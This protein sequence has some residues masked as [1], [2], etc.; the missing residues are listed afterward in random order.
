MTAEYL[1]NEINNL[2]C[3]K[4][5]GIDAINVH[6]LEI[7]CNNLLPSLLDLYLYNSSVASGIFPDQWK[8]SKI[9]PVLKKGSRQDKDD[10]RPISVLSVL[11]KI[12]ERYYRMHLISY[13]HQYNLLRSSQFGSRSFHSCE[14]M[15]LHSMDKGELSGI[16][17]VDFRKAFDLINHELLLQKLAIYGFKD[18]TLQW[19]GSYLT[20]RKQLVSIDHSTSDRLP[21]RSGVPQ[22]SS[23]GPL[24]FILFINDILLA[25]NQCNS[26]IYVDDTTSVDSGLTINMVRTQELTTSP[27]GHMRTEWRQYI[28]TRPKL[29]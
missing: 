20:E 12:L 13:F 7:G 28:L 29:C 3:H 18:A 8:I 4:A 15:L 25:N 11:S 6:L 14:T 22:D 26:Y 17:L 27:P 1:F 16:L 10:Y 21:V 19:F 23:L 5:K 24:L 2:S 9:T